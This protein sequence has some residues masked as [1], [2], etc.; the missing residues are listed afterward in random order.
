M[1]LTEN[2]QLTIPTHINFTLYKYD[3]IDSLIISRVFKECKNYSIV[4]S[5]HKVKVSDF[6]NSLTSS[7]RLNAEL[8]RMS[9]E[10]DHPNFKPNSIYFINT[11]INS[12]SNLDWI[13]FRVSHEKE[14]SRIIKLKDQELLNFYYRIEEGYLDLPS[15]LT[16][17][18]LDL[19]NKLLISLGAIPND[20]LRRASYFYIKASS[21]LELLVATKFSDKG[22]EVA[23]TILDLIDPKIDE[24]DPLLTV[25]TDYTLY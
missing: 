11:I 21:L 2:F 20:Y 16:R 10:I 22:S 17:K 23:D 3:L 9:N 1:M 8:K 6:M 4:S 14:Y 12:L 18:E 24:D 5:V 13:S 25:K 7:P 15:V 19:F